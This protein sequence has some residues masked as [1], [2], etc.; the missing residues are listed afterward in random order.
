MADLTMP[1]VPD[2]LKEDT[3]TIHARM[4]SKAPS[5][6]STMEGDFFWSITR[7]VAE[8]EY[9]HRQLMMAFIKL[10]YLGTSYDGYLDLI[11]AAIGVIRKDATKTKDTI[12]IKGVSGT[13]IQN[14]K[15]AST[16]S[17]EDNRSIEFQFLESKTIDDTAIVEIQVECTEA[18]TVGNVKANTITILTTPIN[19]VQSIANDHDFISGTDVESNDDYKKRILEKMQKPETS[20]NKAQYKNWAK[21]VPGVGDAKVF[22]LWNGNGTVKVVIINA[23]KKAAD[24]ELVQK[25]KDYIDPEPEGKGEGQAPIGAVCTVVSAAEKAMNITASVVLASGYTLQ[26]AQDNFNTVFEKYL[27]D[28]AFNDT[29]VSYAKVGG[30]LLSAGGIVDYSNLTLNNGTANIPLNDEEIPVVGTVDLQI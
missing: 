11:G 4:L 18:G 17:T 26:Q 27:N 23:N 5:D 8:E 15:I 1:A 29:Y 3:D 16:V 24:S 14:G 19:G 12:K 20:A 7:P 2:F 13:V 21:E 30:I 25:V 22:P 6:I 10:V 9:K 28:L